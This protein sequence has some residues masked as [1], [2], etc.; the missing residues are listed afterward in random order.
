MWQT[1][2][3]VSSHQI[4]PYHMARIFSKNSKYGDLDLLWSFLH[5]WLKFVAGSWMD[6]RATSVEVSVLKIFS[7]LY[8]T[9]LLL[10][11]YLMCVFYFILFIDNVFFLF[12]SW[13]RDKYLYN[14][15]LSDNL[16]LEHHFYI[17]YYTP[18]TYNRYPTNISFYTDIQS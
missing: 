13:T 14:F 18:I 7:S 6:G 4:S 8:F 1:I 12:I 10:S 3:Q 16:W 17:F 11:I 5:T 15:F 2:L 9:T